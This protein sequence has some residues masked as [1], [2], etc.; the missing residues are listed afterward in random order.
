MRSVAAGGQP[1]CSG[2][3]ALG[4]APRSSSDSARLLRPP[5]PRP[6]P[7]RWA[8]RAGP[9][10]SALRARTE[11][12][13]SA[14]GCEADPGDEM[15]TSTLQVS[16]RGPAGLR[17]LKEARLGLWASTPI[18]GGPSWSS[19]L[20]SLA[21]QPCRCLRPFL[22]SPARNRGAASRPECPD[23]L[24]ERR[25]PE[26]SMCSWRSGTAVALSLTRPHRLG[27]AVGLLA[28]PPPPFQQ[29]SV[30]SPVS[31]FLFSARDPSF[32]P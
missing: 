8:P 20:A 30:L 6:A 7:I 19:S 23:P 4:R 10:T 27:P 13:S 15:T 18:G 28:L 31:D 22:C 16:R 24:A 25:S 17:R 14:A 21:P 1:H 32:I 2:P 29:T 5:S 26:A 3:T 11:A 12:A 9:R